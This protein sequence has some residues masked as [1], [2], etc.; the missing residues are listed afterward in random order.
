MRKCLLIILLLLPTLVS[1]QGWYY[2]AP[3]AGGAS[4]TERATENFNRADG[5][6]GA[7]WTTWAT[8]AMFVN[9]NGAR[10][11]VQNGANAGAFY[12][13]YGSWTADQAS[14]ATFVNVNNG[15]DYSGVAVRCTG[16]GATANGY[17]LLT[18][19]STGTG[20]TMLVRLDNG[21]ETEIQAIATT[22]ADGNAGRIEIEGTNIKCYKNTGS[23]F[24]QIGTTYTSATEYSSGSPGAYTY[25]TNNVIQIDDWRGE[26]K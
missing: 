22:F 5:A 15:A 3:A 4:W 18:D 12:S 1:A 26:D 17:A 23:G 16:T 7:S 2:A 14:E 20:H 8:E 10:D 21:A 25:R 6:L 11:N 13:G 24:V 19:G 9:T